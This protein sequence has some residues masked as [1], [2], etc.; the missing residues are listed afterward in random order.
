MI[1]TTNYVR[2]TG[3]LGQDVQ[4]FN[5]ESGSKKAVFSL[6]TTENYKNQKGEW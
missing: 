1:N 5:F 2:L 3:N 4:L 6:A